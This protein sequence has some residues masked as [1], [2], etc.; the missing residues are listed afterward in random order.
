MLFLLLTNLVAN[1]AGRFAGRLTRS[2][3][4][5]A[6]TRMYG[7]LQRGFIHSNNMLRH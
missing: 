1:G 5:A 2:L 4:F 7:F 6:A 3:A